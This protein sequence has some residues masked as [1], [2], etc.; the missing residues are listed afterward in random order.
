MNNQT[1]FPNQNNQFNQ[2]AQTPGPIIQSTPQSTSPIQ[3]PVAPQ[4]MQPTPPQNTVISPQT[5][6]APA[7]SLQVNN[8][9]QSK[10]K[11]DKKK[12][13]SNPNSTQNSIQIAEIRDNIVILKDSTFRAVIAC[14]SINFDLMSENERDGVEYTYQNFLNSLYFPVQIL[15]RSQRVDI[16]PY[17]EKMMKLRNSQDNM[18]LNILMD[19]YI[20]YIDMLS[21]EANIMDKTF[22][23]VVPYMPAGDILSAKAQ[24]KGIFSKVNNTPVTNVKINHQVYSKAVEEITNRVNLVISGLSQVGVHAERLDTKKLSQLYYN[25]YNPDTALRQ[26]LISFDKVT[27]LYSKKGEGQISRFNLS[28]GDL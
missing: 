25:F 2:T 11:K 3:S 24:V 19:D 9:N 6:Q 13:G 4:Y 22:Y 12:P 10:N 18:L 1:V 27:N 15:V 21:Q 17:L 20:N 28:D 14:E 16:G 8:Q 5:N 23:I 26:P 7:P